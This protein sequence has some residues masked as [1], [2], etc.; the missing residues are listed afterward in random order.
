MFL[1]NKTQKGSFCA[2]LCT[3]CGVIQGPEG[4]GFDHRAG[5]GREV[6]RSLPARVTTEVV[7]V[8]FL[9]VST[10]SFDVTT[11]VDGFQFRHGSTFLWFKPL[12]FLH[13]GFSNRRAGHE[14]NHWELQS[15]AHYHQTCRGN[16]LWVTP[17]GNLSREFSKHKA[18]L[19]HQIQRKTR[20]TPAESCSPTVDAASVA[21][22]CLLS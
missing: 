6:G 1:H 2:A 18:R 4:P 11:I 19:C 22:C 10:Q 13:F 5:G 21:C 12:G 15:M 17:F 16:A 20:S 9:T 3:T 7:G 8:K 14:Q